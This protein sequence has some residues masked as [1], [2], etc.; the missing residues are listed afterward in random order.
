M[1]RTRAPGTAWSRPGPDSVVVPRSRPVLDHPQNPPRQ[2]E[3]GMPDS[4]GRK[5]RPEVD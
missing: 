4:D 3:P 5:A 1:A 2:L